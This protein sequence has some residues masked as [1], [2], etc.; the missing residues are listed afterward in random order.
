MPGSGAASDGSGRREIK[1]RIHFS[2]ENPP[3]HTN[4]NVWNGLEGCTGC[5]APG[6]LSQWNNAKDSSNNSTGYHF[7][8]DQTA[9]EPDIIIKLK[10][11]L[12][13]FA[14]AA[15]GQARDSKGN[16]IPGKREIFLSPEILNW[17][18]EDLAAVLAHE[19]G[20]ALGLADKYG[21]TG[22]QTILNQ[23]NSTNGRPLTKRVQPNDVQM[24]N[25]HFADRLQCSRNRRTSMS[26][27]TSVTPTPTPTPT[28]CTDNDSDGICLQ[29]DCDDFN[30][31]SSYDFDGDGFCNG[32]DCNDYNP[33]IYPGAPL[34][35]E[36]SGGED[37]NCNGQDD[38]DEQGLGPC[39][40]LREKQCRDA[41]KDW[42]AGHCQCTFFSDPSPVLIDVSG[43]GFALTNY[44]DGVRFDLNNDGVK[45]QL[46]WTLPFSDDSW[47]A[48]DRNG[49]GLIDNG[50][51][52]FGNFTLQPHPPAGEERNGF[53]A[54]AE[55]DKPATG[56]NG[57][58]F[59][60]R[61]D[62]IFHLLILWQDF[63]HNGLSE[64]SEL[65]P[66]ESVGLKR[67][68]LDYQHSKKVDNHGNE[69]RY[70][71]KVKD[72]QD[73]Q[74]GRWAWDVFLINRP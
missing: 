61:V 53:L 39:G 68:E 34:D 60:S 16:W 27:G 67:I 8:L 41:G 38:Y 12:P 10:T 31:W 44:N 52:L 73:A 48:L 54:L 36:T 20:H 43:D 63:N 7:K 14:P 3:G 2:L 72:A 18:Q 5:S 51:E 56:G 35:P 17:S 29:H 42:D 62:S 22:C 64:F 40:W 19:I 74:L 28:E 4:A 6:A 15:S 21:N 47:L 69:F 71:A 25:K 66:L 9:Q 23:G 46:S 50:F 45:E 24:V 32:S 49:N 55:F 13:E 37:R 65:F 70:R 30:Y 57:D 11:D 59:I 26:F 33:A 1:V 58:G